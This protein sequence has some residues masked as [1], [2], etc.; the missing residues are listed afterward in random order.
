MTDYG[1]NSSYQGHYGW[2]RGAGARHAPRG[3]SRGGGQWNPLW[4][5]GAWGNSWSDA[6]DATA[7]QPDPLVKAA[8]KADQV[9]VRRT[10]VLERARDRFTELQTDIATMQAWLAPALAEITKY[11]QARDDARAAKEETDAALAATS[12]PWQPRADNPLAQQ[13]ASILGKVSAAASQTPA[14][15]EA[16]AALLEAL[17][18][19]T[20]DQ[21]P[22]LPCTVD[23][24]DDDVAAMAVEEADR[25]AL[26]AALSAAADLPTLDER[27]TAT[28]SAMAR[29]I[30][31]AER[32]GA[33]KPRLQAAQG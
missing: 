32:N 16:M 7:T 25:L 24:L 33:K 4:K 8:K 1:W 28:A 22:H 23:D 9:L 5:Y 26:H 19:A 2:S 31:H 20:T 10:E 29:Y 18:V 17:Q 12:G 14:V 30:P 6:Q 15:Q 3:R 27:K 13:L 21:R 11:E